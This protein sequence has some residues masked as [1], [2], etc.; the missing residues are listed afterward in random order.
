[1][2]ASQLPEAR[3]IIR[4]LEYSKARELAEEVLSLS[5][6]TEIEARLEA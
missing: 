1:M 4:N 5:T 6:R 2:T 3:Y